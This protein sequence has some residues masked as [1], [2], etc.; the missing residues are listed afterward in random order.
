MCLSDP[1]I[2]DLDACRETLLTGAG[3]A[4][5][6]KLLGFCFLIWANKVLEFSRFAFGF[7]WW[8]LSGFWLA[9]MDLWD[10]VSFCFCPAIWTASLVHHGQ[11][12]AMFAGE[13]LVMD[14]WGVFLQTPIASMWQFWVA[15]FSGFGCLQGVCF[16]KG[17]GMVGLAL[18]LLSLLASVPS[19]LYWEN[20]AKWNLLGP[21]D[22]LVM[23]LFAK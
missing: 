23:V 15:V 7:V 16:R 18:L 11:A 6:G 17:L 4:F 9:V 19:P 20:C 8:I 21:D 13:R 14:Y 5:E 10:F 1:C 22:L 3:G 12:A 2:A